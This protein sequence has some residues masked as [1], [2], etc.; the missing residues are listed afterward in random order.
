MKELGFDI[1]NKCNLHINCELDDIFDI[2]LEQDIVFCT[3]S[4]IDGEELMDIKFNGYGFDLYNPFTLNLD[5]FNNFEFFS[6]IKLTIPNGL[7]IFIKSSIPGLSCISEKYDIYDGI[8]LPQTTLIDDFSNLTWYTNQ[9]NYQFYNKSQFTLKEFNRELFIKHS[10]T[11]YKSTIKIPPNNKILEL[12]FVET[13]IGR[14]APRNELYLIH[15]D[16][17]YNNFPDLGGFK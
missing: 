14:T 6:R 12:Y 7:K 8:I 4:I 9:I 16:Y 5:K 3:P 11:N 10:S 15:S 2:N 1:D 13:F 17:I